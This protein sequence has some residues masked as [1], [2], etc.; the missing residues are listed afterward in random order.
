V[1]H[2]LKDV[3]MLEQKV[4]TLEVQKIDLQ[5][6]INMAHTRLMGHERVLE[7]FIEG[8]GSIKLQAEIDRD[9]DLYDYKQSHT[10][11]KTS[12]K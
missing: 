7:K 4:E 3:H 11:Q 12:A 9:P 1:A 2:A 6:E 10:D 5:R 8:F